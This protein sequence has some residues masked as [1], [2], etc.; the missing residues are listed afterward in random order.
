MIRGSLGFG[1]Q[2]CDIVMM[3]LMPYMLR[4]REFGVRIYQ[5]TGVGIGADGPILTESAMITV[6]NIMTP[7]ETVV[8]VGDALSRTLALMQRHRHSCALVVDAGR[9]IGLLTERDLSDVLAQ[10]LELGGLSDCAVGEVMT[11][12]PQCLEEHAS[13]LDALKLA[14]D[15]HI[16]HFPVLGESGALVGIVTQTDMANA[17]IRILERQTELIQ[18]NQTLER[19][20]LRD[21]LLAVRNRR[22]MDL[23]LSRVLA[24]AQSLGQSMAVGLLDLDRF[25]SY[26]DYYGHLAG[27]QALKSVAKAVEE[28]LRQGD[29]LYRY[30]GEELLLLMPNTDLEGAWQG[31]DR[32]R[33]AVERLN[34]EHVVSPLG[35]LTLSGGVAAGCTVDADGLIAAA[36]RAMYQAKSAGRN[37]VF[38]TRFSPTPAPED[39]APSV[40]S[41]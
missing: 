36:D 32:A 1:R 31:A 28:N 4:C 20:S 11:P 10:S 23:D 19:A 22:A 21:P 41:E 25:K 13:L 35:R 26:N 7:V 8:E 9:V 3:I 39:R 5:S 29:T 12:E 14:R 17:Y 2:K 16:R 38:T 6:Q 24:Q 33:Q 27:D 40:E 18:T 37:Q 34:I 30:G 15:L